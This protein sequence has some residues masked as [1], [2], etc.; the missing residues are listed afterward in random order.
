MIFV[1]IEKN[2]GDLY[3][4]RMEELKTVETVIQDVVKEFGSP[5]SIDNGDMSIRVQ[6]DGYCVYVVAV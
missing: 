6:Y 2:D 5:L 4:H 1:H 3:V